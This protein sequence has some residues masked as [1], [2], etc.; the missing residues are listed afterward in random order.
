MEK[1]RIYALLSSLICLGAVALNAQPRVFSKAGKARVAG[2][3]VLVHV[4]VGVPLG[5]DPESVANAAVRAQGGIPLTALEFSTTGLVWDQFFD[6]AGGN[7]LVSQRYNPTDD[8][9]GIGQAV[10]VKTQETWSYSAVTGSAFRLAFVGETEK[11]PSLVRECKGPQSFDGS[12]DVAWVPLSDPFTLA[13]TWSSSSVDEADMAMN[14]KQNWSFYDA[15]SVLLHENGHVAGLGHSS[16]PNAVMVAT[17]AGIRR[18]LGADDIAGVAFL[19]PLSSEPPPDL[20]GNG[21][22]DGAEECDGS[23]LSGQTCT[24][25]GYS[26]GDLTCSDTCTLDTSGCTTEDSACT[27]L[28]L[29]D[30]CTFDGQC[31]SGKCR[32][33]PGAAV[34]K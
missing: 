26:S 34:C 13:V 20:C 23:N 32:G 15:E 10:L 18:A 3:D 24:T 6:G 9:T 22:L 7:D 27:L 5:L 11:C 1:I 8:P 28:Q 30:P 21:L 31:C 19:Y 16:D 2:Q 12:N 4:T 33:K 29:G 14:T 17:Y 25:Q